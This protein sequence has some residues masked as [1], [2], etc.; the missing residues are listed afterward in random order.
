MSNLKFPFSKLG[1][2]ETC[3]YKVDHSMRILGVF[4][5]FIGAI[6]IVM[7]ILGISIFSDRLYNN[8]T[9]N[10]VYSFYVT[11]IIVCV[12]IFMIWSVLP[13][14]KKELISVSKLLEEIETI[15]SGKDVSDKKQSGEGFIDESLE[16]IVIDLDSDKHV[17]HLTINFDN[18]IIDR[19]ATFPYMLQFEVN[20]IKYS[21]PFNIYYTK[22]NLNWNASTNEIYIFYK[23]NNIVNINHKKVIACYST[24]IEEQPIVSL[25]NGQYV[26]LFSS[27][28]KH[29]Y[30][31]VLS[32]KKEI[33]IKQHFDKIVTERIV[34]YET[35][36]KSYNEG[37]VD[38]QEEDTKE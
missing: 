8:I 6:A 23:E 18:G 9:E 16:Q 35:D 38:K 14:Y 1:L 37:F 30:D 29:L 3:R 4:T 11:G 24:P 33:Q 21:L 34:V 10:T 5:L 2:I 26:V 19:T 22:S 27:I 7:C 36:V 17:E 32:L 15:A 13:I 25:V 28:Q 31:H 12:I 20:N